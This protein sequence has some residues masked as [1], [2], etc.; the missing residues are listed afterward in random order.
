[1]SRALVQP[2]EAVL[3]QRAAE[4]LLAR[5]LMPW[6]SRRDQA[7]LRLLQLASIAA[8]PSALAGI[9]ADA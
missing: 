2:V 7:S 5:G 6:L 1:M 8:P 3:E 9:D 4:A